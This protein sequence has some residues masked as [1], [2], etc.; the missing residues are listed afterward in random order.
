M[1]NSFVFSILATFLKSQQI[2]IYVPD[3][4]KYNRFYDFNV[5]D[6]DSKFKYTDGF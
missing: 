3:K 1:R 6:G 4:N 5:T 2:F